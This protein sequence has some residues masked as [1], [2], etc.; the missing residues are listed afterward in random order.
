[1]KNLGDENVMDGKSGA[2]YRA[3]LSATRHQRTIKAVLSPPGARTCRA[4]QGHSPPTRRNNMTPLY[5][6]ARNGHSNVVESP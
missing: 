5:M 4:E 6:A 3:T 2:S 1:M